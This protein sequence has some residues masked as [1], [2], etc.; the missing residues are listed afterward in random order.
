MVQAKSLAT[1]FGRQ[2]K[3]SVPDVDIK[4]VAV[5]VSSPQPAPGEPGEL[6]RSLLHTVAGVLL[7][8]CVSTRACVRLN[9]N[10]GT[11]YEVASKD[12]PSCP[13]MASRF[14]DYNELRFG[15]RPLDGRGAE[16]G[17]FR[18]LTSNP[19][20]LCTRMGLIK[21]IGR[22]RARCVIEVTCGAHYGK[23]WALETKFKQYVKDRRNRLVH[24]TV[25]TKANFEQTFLPVTQRFEMLFKLHQNMCVCK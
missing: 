19:G 3:P 20:Y 1:R 21:R 18:V 2:I 6:R 12:G 22:N 14:L 11:G 17:S 15:I 9:I 24:T 5:L 25:Q 4:L 23:K 13:A 16:F 7:R 10:T 8:A